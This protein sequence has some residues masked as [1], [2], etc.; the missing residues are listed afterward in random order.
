[1]STKQE[2]R[3][4]KSD[5][6]LKQHYNLIG[7]DS[8]RRISTVLAQ[9]EEEQHSEKNSLSHAPTIITNTAI[10]NHYKGSQETLRSNFSLSTIE[11][12]KHKQKKILVLKD[13]DPKTENEILNKIDNITS[14]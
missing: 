5:G 4:K 6:S 11:K 13:Y 1:M 2:P 7:G 8:R 14:S 3:A 10:V 9:V 12:K